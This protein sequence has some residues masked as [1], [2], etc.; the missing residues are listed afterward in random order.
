MYCTMLARIL[1]VRQRFSNLWVATCSW[2]GHSG[3]RDSVLGLKVG[4][5]ML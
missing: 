1:L 3:S 2:R 4:H 5:K